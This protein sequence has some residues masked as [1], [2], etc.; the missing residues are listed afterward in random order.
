MTT[1]VVTKRAATKPCMVSATQNRANNCGWTGWQVPRCSPR[2]NKSWGKMPTGPRLAHCRWPCSSQFGERQA[3]TECAPENFSLDDLLSWVERAAQQRWQQTCSQALWLFAVHLG[4]LH[5]GV[6]YWVWRQTGLCAC[7]H[8]AAL[9]RPSHS[10]SAAQ[11]R[12][13]IGHCGT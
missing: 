10:S 12:P 2:V 3:C 5:L 4:A 6:E 8:K 11:R 1:S 9:Q 7:E 13:A